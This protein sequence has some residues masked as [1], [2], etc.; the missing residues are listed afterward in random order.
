[1]GLLD[2]MVFL[3]VGFEEFSFCFSVCVP[4]DTPTVVHRVPFAPHLANICHLCPLMIAILTDV[5]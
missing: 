5:R 3:F 1:M 4:T 2:H